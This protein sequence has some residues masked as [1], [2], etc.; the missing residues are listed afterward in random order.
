MARNL[1]VRQASEASHMRSQFNHMQAVLESAFHDAHLVSFRGE[2]DLSY[3]WG[4]VLPSVIV[5]YVVWVS[6]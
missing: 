3:S 1:F 4:K 2:V 5:H 6:C